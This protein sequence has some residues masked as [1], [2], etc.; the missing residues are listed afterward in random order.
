MCSRTRVC[1]SAADSPTKAAAA[2]AKKRKEQE[3]AEVI[4]D[5]DDADVGKKTS[6]TPK[7]E[8][9]ASL[10]KG[11]S[12]VPSGEESGHHVKKSPAKPRALPAWAG[13]AKN[14][15]EDVT[16]GVKGGA[17][18]DKKDQAGASLK[19]KVGMRNGVSVCSVRF[20]WVFLHGR[21]PHKSP[22]TS[23]Q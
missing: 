12:F 22:G 16:S 18:H 6:K 9:L 4:T 13:G 23:A 19:H 5:S 17:F 10:A 2:S 1:K 11:G 8:D 3:T 21:A 14:K 20:L 7:L 15:Q